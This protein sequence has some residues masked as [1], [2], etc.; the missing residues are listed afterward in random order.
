[1]GISKVSLLGRIAKMVIDTGATSS[2]LSL[3]HA[4]VRTMKPWQQSVR[5]SIAN[6]EQTTVYGLCGSDSDIGLRHLPYRMLVADVINNISL[7][8]NAHFLKLDNDGIAM[9]APQ[10]SSRSQHQKMHSVQKTVSMQVLG[11]QKLFSLWEW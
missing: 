2:I 9:S 11:E 8:L 1:M 3:A 10:F 6:G 7:D 4:S 5:L